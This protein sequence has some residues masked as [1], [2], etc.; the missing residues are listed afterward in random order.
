MKASEADTIVEALQLLQA[1]AE[2]QLEGFAIEVKAEGTS[3]IND[4]GAFCCKDA[5][6]TETVA[7]LR[8]L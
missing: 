1:I 4:E 7:T 5:T 3:I 8:A 6:P 2:D